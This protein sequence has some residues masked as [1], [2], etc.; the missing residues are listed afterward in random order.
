MR[1]DAERGKARNEE[2]GDER[3]EKRE[4]GNLRRGWLRHLGGKIERRIRTQEVSGLSPTL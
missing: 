3:Y 1:R 4:Q 2:C